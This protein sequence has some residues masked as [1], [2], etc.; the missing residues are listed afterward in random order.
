[1]L[2]LP[3]SQPYSLYCSTNRKIS[4]DFSL[5][6]PWYFRCLV[7]AGKEHSSRNGR[8]VAGAGKVGSYLE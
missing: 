2:A 3:H 7:M 4:D 6:D 8:R 5:A 1:M